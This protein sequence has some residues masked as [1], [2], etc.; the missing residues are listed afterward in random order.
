MISLNG[1]FFLPKNI[2]VGPDLVKLFFEIHSVNYLFIYL[3]II[4]IVQ[5]YTQKYCKSINHVLYKPIK[6]LK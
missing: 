1:D 5:W 4:E 6:T 2:Y 3:F